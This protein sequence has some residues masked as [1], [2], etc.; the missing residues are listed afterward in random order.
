MA[1]SVRLLAQLTRQVAL[2]QYPSLVQSTVLHIELVRL[3]ESRLLLVLIA[4]T[5]RVEQRSIDLPAAMTEDEVTS[6][7][8]R[9]VASAI[10]E[11]CSDLGDQLTPLV[12]AAT[13]ELR[14]AVAA[15]VASLIEATAD[16]VE[17]RIVL[18]GTAN[19][20]RYR[21]SF[22]ISLEPVLEALEEQV[23][24]LRLLGEVSGEVTVRIGHE[25][26][27]ED[28]QGTSLV[29]TGY[30]RGDSVVAGVGVV[31]PTHMDYPGTMASV[32]AVAQYLSQILDEN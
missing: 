20:A 9:L 3:S 16:T 15:V 11:R 6:L 1:R 24:L 13:P 26:P 32:R 23:V 4:D 14:P 2:V 29:A 22:S 8:A 12:D 19:L 7:R 5:G 18:G 31:G 30:G 27:V 17:Q 21:D 28:L 10:G 25:N